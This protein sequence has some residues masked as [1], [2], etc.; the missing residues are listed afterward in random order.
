VASFTMTEQEA[1]E[2]EVIPPNTVLETTV[3]EVNVKESPFLIDEN[4]PSKGKKQQVS[5]KFKVNEE[6]DYQNRVL[7]GN[8][9]TTFT[10][11]PDCKLR[12]WVGEILGLDE[13]GADFTFDTDHLVGLTVKVVVGNRPRKHTDGSVTQTDF[14]E[15]VIRMSG[16][17]PA[18]EI[19]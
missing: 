17:A 8:T 14:A 12:A 7:W 9:P 18:D 4:D 11:H 13:I 15:G 10:T 3:E 5:F 1:P 6:G 2:F 19:F 16:A